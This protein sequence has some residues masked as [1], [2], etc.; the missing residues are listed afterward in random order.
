MGMGF[1]EEYLERIYRIYL[2]HNKVVHYRDG[3]PVRSLTTPAVLSKP[4]AHFMARALYKTIQNRSLP[5]MLSFAVNDGCNAFCQHCSFFQGVE[6]KGRPVLT[7]Q[8][9]QK[10]VR[11]AQELGVSVINF[12]GGEPL[13]RQD[14]PQILQ[15]VDKDL[16]ATLLVTNGS[17]LAERARELR[18]A[19]LDSVFVSI[20]SAD[21]EK[22]DRFRGSK[23]LFAKATQGIRT[24]KTAGLS[25]GISCTLTPESFQA[26]ELERLI[27]LG[28]TLGVHEVLVFDAMPSGRYQARE[29]LV[30]NWGWVEQ[31]IA[32][33]RPYNQDPRYP[34][35]MVWAYV[36]SYRSVGCGCGTSYF[37]VSPY[38]DVMSCDFN[39]AKFGSVLQA[40]LY[41][42]W[43]HLSS[44]EGF[45]RSKWGGCK[46][47]DSAYLGKPTV[48]VGAPEDATAVISRR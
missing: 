4:A 37:Y 39:H 22:H 48:V 9:A 12:V 13:L 24:A 38:G 3:H 34:G 44:Q 14:L 20:D 5:N 30:D 31:V 28:R 23:G 19:G 6:E 1:Q 15:A 18:R 36:S 40:P 42:I 16:S 21:P 17:L 7:T 10:L 35:V 27:E 45:C 41:Q 29:D 11:D 43:D 32:A 33:A 8:Q 25:V 2:N 47:K 26:G 46:V